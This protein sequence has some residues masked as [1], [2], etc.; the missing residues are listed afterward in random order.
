M[1]YRDFVLEIDAIDARSY[2]VRVALSPAGQGEG[3]FELPFDPKDLS[4]VLAGVAQ[5]VR[6]G[7][8][9]ADSRELVPQ[10]QEPLVLEAPVL[11]PLSPRQ[12]GER[13]FQALFRGQVLSRYERSLGEI[14]QLPDTGLRIQLKLNPRHPHLAR[15]YAL[16]W[17]FLF[18]EDTH[19]F[20]SLKLRTPVV[21][22]LDVPRP[23]MP[24]PRLPPTLRILVVIASPTGYAPLDLERERSDLAEAWGASDAVELTFLE[25]GDSESVHEAL[26]AGRHHILHYMG[27]GGFDPASG[28]GTLLFES[29]GSGEPQPLSGRALAVELKNFRSLRLVFLNACDTARATDADGCDPFGGVATAL[30][31]GGLP[32][33]VA[34]Q[35]PISDRAAIVF[36]RKVYQRLAEGHP[37]DIAVAEGRLAIYR[38]DPDTME[39]GTPVLFLRSPDGRLFETGAAGTAEISADALAEFAATSA[40]QSVRQR[41][42]RRRRKA[43]TGR[44]GWLVAAIAAATLAAV[45]IVGLL[46]RWGAHRS[47]AVS[48]TRPALAILPPRN[49]SARPV[50]DW[51]ATAAAEALV[52]E[53]ATGGLVRAVGGEGVARALRELGLQVTETPS[54]EDLRRLRRYLDIDFLITGGYSLTAGPGDPQLRLDLRVLEA[55]TGEI[56][57]SIGD[58][59]HQS[60]LFELLQELSE[61]LRAWLG[62]AEL[63]P[64]QARAVRASL[65]TDPQAERLYSEGLALLRR[66]DA[67]GARDLLLQAIEAEPEHPMPY[68]ALA[69]AWS[70][71]GYD[72]DARQAARQAL[73]RSGSLPLWQQDTIAAR[74]AELE[75]DWPRA[76]EIYATLFRTQ[77]D[78]LASGLRLAEAQVASGETE[79]ALSTL[80]ELRR[81]PSPAPEDPRI[82]LVEAD[83]RYRLGDL[84]EAKLAATRAFTRGKALGAD[85][86]AARALRHE[87]RALQDLGRYETARARLTAAEALYLDVGDRRGVAMVRELRAFDRLQRSG[88]L[89]EALEFFESSHAVYLEIGDEKS[90]AR[91]SGT[92]GRV[93][94]DRGELAEAEKWLYGA[95]QT[96]ERIGARLEAGAQRTEIGYKLQIQGEL[97]LA[98]T[99][100]EAAWD[101]YLAS[102]SRSGQAIALT[103]M[104]EVHYLRGDLDRAWELHEQALAINRD[105]GDPSGEAYDTLRLGKVLAARGQLP[106]ARGR[107]QEALALQ[108]D[109]YVEAEV[110]LALTALELLEGRA[111]KAAEMARQIK[112]RL[113]Q[114]GA[115]DTAARAQILLVSS[116]LAQGNVVPAR[117]AYDSAR[118]LVETGGDFLAR[119]DM[120]ILG[121]RLRATSGDAQD[122][123]EV[124]QSLEIASEEAAEAGFLEASFE[125]RLAI[126]Q[127]ATAHR[128]P[129]ATSR[130][131][132]LAADARRS[133][134]AQIAQRAARSETVQH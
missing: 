121:A 109:V 78:D 38:D 45:V 3:A 19:D 31:M 14:G 46:M 76:I 42:S 118:N 122:V 25:H 125:A 2:Q 83:C 129:T 48:G 117:E 90:S 53:L 40:G 82:D 71:L 56:R 29:P 21:R 39:W 57:T 134:F 67:R 115:K 8:E 22:Y 89:G 88:N 12:V 126:G 52:T 116:L 102:D 123:D 28:E 50:D 114:Q 98:L 77:A 37:V 111:S 110:R 10:E 130:L 35:F 113:L 128:R 9:A 15:F 26:L 44:R 79:E 133:G 49:L 73:E 127:I 17:E 34:M 62:A 132:Q 4:R 81:L 74:T 63:S 33:V 106:A 86:L 54:N 93:Q 72:A 58:N 95:F 84:R 41:L 69:M 60:Q 20:L 96:L 30:V 43:A 32:A 87:A 70:E 103:N 27:H 108:Q 65:P 68:D 119:L 124:L 18:Q 61:S 36:S 75:H 91:V 107:Y 1:I 51:I 7:G 112:E 105:I 47:A 55:Q 131:G 101:L 13:L 94:L 100:Y 99:N 80:E 23:T 85:L 11:E 97:E 6:R 104:A 59:G 66:L 16:P 92:I 24:P 5:A 120:A 64:A